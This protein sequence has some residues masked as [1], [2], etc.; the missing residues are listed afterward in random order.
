ML[1][2]TGC[3]AVMLGRAA[4]GDPWVFRR[5]RARWERGEDLPPPTA[6]ERLEAGL[7]HLDMMVRA[8]G[9]DVA[10]R[11]MR[12]H[13]AWYVKGLP[14]ASAVR[15]QANRIETADAL[16]ELLLGFLERLEA[17]RWAA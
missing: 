12:K 17:A 3:D 4:F 7:R 16:D 5:V 9:A 14:G 13:V 11:E 15:D 1:E 10:A 2:S 6:A 8:V